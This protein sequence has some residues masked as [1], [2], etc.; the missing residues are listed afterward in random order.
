M[1]EVLPPQT[2]EGAG[3]E[4]TRVRQFTIF[5]EN[6]VGRLQQLV[7]SLEQGVGKIVAL[8]IEE[9]GDTALVRL[10]CAEPDYGREL[11]T[12]AGF[13]FAESELLAVELPKRTK[14][15]LL[16]VCSALLAAEINIHY[17]YP[18]LRRPSGPSLALFVDDPTLAA[19]L[20][21]KKGFTLI[22]ESDLRG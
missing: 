3:H 5:M 21:I 10:I 2:L 20:L 18:L 8:S 7:R 1:E 4:S 11:L 22:G 15:P 12:T 16:Q 14:Q 6:K 19:Q 13:A 17:A 9:S